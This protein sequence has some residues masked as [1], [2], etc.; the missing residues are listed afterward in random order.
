M[1]QKQQD[2]LLGL[3]LWAEL[4]MIAHGARVVELGVDPEVPQFRWAKSWKAQGGYYPMEGMNARVKLYG[5]M[6]WVQG[7][8]QA[9][10]LTE[11]DAMRLVSGLVIGMRKQ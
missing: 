2:R 5:W 8:V 6:P 10:R 11:H 9:P 7:G 4:L 3:A 1:S